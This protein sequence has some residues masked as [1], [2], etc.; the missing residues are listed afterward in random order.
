MPSSGLLDF[1]S[2]SDDHTHSGHDRHLSQKPDIAYETSVDR[3]IFL[4][5]SLP[6][7]PQ[8]VG[9]VSRV[10]DAAF[11][12]SSGPPCLIREVLLPPTQEEQCPSIVY[13]LLEEARQAHNTG[14]Y[15]VGLTKLEEAYRVWRAKHHWYEIRSGADYKIVFEDDKEPHSGSPMPGD[16]SPEPSPTASADGKTEALSPNHDRASELAA[17]P[18][19]HAT[20]HDLLSPASASIH[21]DTTATG[22]FGSSINT[23]SATSAT[24]EKKKRKSKREMEREKL[25]RE[26]EERRADEE[27]KAREFE[28]WKLAN[29]TIPLEYELEFGLFLWN[30]IGSLFQSK[31]ADDKALVS[32]WRAKQVHDDYLV[33]LTAKREEEAAEEKAA[34]EAERAREG[35]DEKRENESALAAAAAAERKEAAEA[36]ENFRSLSLLGSSVSRHSFDDTASSLRPTLLPFDYCSPATA[37]TYSNM[38]AALYHLKRYDLALRCFYT[39]Q[40]IRFL[41]LN[42]SSDEFVDIGTTLNNIGVCL[43]QLDRFQESYLYMQSAEEIMT[44]RLELIHPRLT[45]VRSNLD[46]V[47]PKRKQINLSSA[48]LDAAANQVAAAQKTPSTL[49]IPAKKPV[50]RSLKGSSTPLT[51]A[52]KKAAA[53]KAATPLASPLDLR[54]WRVKMTT[55]QRMLQENAARKRPAAAAAKRAPAKGAPKR[56]AS[57]PKRTAM[58]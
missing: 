1:G 20:G 9:E 47:R 54:Q 45:A 46:K 36:E 25:Q 57:P 52:A 39:A 18:T 11:V 7:F 33:K 29:P 43:F 27:R 8:H 6:E 16:V 19:H 42:V 22:T 21:D 5:G 38:G 31:L 28:A 2:I 10:P 48:L 23:M 24:T 37:L 14:Q 17:S 44:Q 53:L 26:E 15:D 55:Y 35:N 13:E 58:R 56:G 30:S 3:V 40:Q 32:F 50:S 34:W 51:A 49:V 4:L 12:I 41:C